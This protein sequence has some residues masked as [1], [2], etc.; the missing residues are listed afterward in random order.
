MFHDNDSRQFLLRGISPETIEK[1]LLHFREGFPYA[2]L[3]KPA[4]VGDG[5]FAFSAEEAHHYEDDGA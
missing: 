3:A 1:Q 2:R 4:T 5:I